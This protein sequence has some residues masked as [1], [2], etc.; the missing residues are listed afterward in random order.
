MGRFIRANGELA[1]RMDTEFSLIRRGQPTKVDGKMTFNM[2][3]GRKLGMAVAFVSKASTLK[4]K[5]MAGVAM[6]G[7]TAVFMKE[8]LSI[9]FSK[10]AVSLIP[11]FFTQYFLTSFFFLT[12]SFWIL[13]YIHPIPL[14]SSISNAYKKSKVN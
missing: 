10:D 5:R 2:E 6:N 11:S 9:Q 8:N 3:K 12:R 4:G 14:I 1:W 13:K 7:P